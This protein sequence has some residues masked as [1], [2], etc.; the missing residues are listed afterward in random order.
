MILLIFFSPEHKFLLLAL[1]VPFA[2]MRTCRKLKIQHHFQM[3]HLYIQQ[4][5]AFMC[6]T[7]NLSPSTAELQTVCTLTQNKVY[8][9]ATGK[10]KP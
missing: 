10:A 7:A 3:P 1:L 2:L 9:V 4:N 5:T 8:R 6:N